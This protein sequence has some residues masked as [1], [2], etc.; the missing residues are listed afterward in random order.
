M[1]PFLTLLLQSIILSLVAIIFGISL[2]TFRSHRLPWRGEW[3]RHVE[4][5]AWQAGLRLVGIATVQQAI[6]TGN[7]RL[8]DARPVADYRA[9]HLPQAQSLPFEFAREMF[10]GMQMD[11]TRGQ[12]IITYCGR[13]DCD[14]GLE[15]ALFLRQMGYTNVALFAGGLA[16]WR[17]AGGPVEATP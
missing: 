11:L 12:P 13:P 6:K 10:A 14:E 15:L 1:K 5:R 3:S 9:A 2:N 16:E 8:L 4:Q 7:V 17:S